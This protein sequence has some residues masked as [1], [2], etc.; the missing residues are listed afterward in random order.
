VDLMP[1]ADEARVPVAIAEAV[2]V[3]EVAGPESID[4]L[5]AG[6]A[7]R[8]LLLVV[9]NCEH[10]IDLVAEI[11][12][13][14]ILRC[15]GVTI[16]AT[17]RET[18]SIDG[19]HAI[20]VRPLGSPEDGTTADELQRHDATRLFVER[21]QAVGTFEPTDADA[22]SIAAICR[23][24][25]G[26]PLAIELAAARTKLLSVTDIE[27]ALDDRFRLL[28]S[29]A[30][31][32]ASRQRTLEASVA[33]SHDLLTEEEQAV[34][35]R[36]GVFPGPFDLDAVAAVAGLGDTM[37]ALDVLTSLVDKSLVTVRPDEHG[38]R[39][40]MLETIRQFALD[41]LTERGEVE[42]TRDAH[43]DHLLAFGESLDVQAYISDAEAMVQTAALFDDL[44]NAVAWAIERG[45]AGD[46]VDLHFPHYVYY[47]VTGRWAD[48]RATVEAVL[49]D[50]GLTLAQQVKAHQMAIGL[51]ASAS[52]PVRG[53]ELA[54]EA[55]RLAREHGDEFLLWGTLGSILSAQVW[56]NT[57][58]SW[59]AEAWEMAGSGKWG[60]GPLML[61]GCFWGAALVYAGRDL[62]AIPVLEAS[63]EAAREMAIPFF[64]V[65]GLTF[66]A[67]AYERLGQVWRTSEF[68][69]RARELAEQHSRRLLGILEPTAGVWE[70]IPFGEYE[71][72]RER[73]R[74]A[75][76]HAG[77]PG[78]STY[79]I[80]LIGLANVAH[81]EGDL[82]TAGPA[83]DEA[84]RLLRK[85][86]NNW[87]LAI[88]L[89]YQAL[90]AA[91]TGDVARARLSL[92]EHDALL[93]S[94]GWMYPRFIGAVARAYIA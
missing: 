21:A 42:A 47:L 27:A 11:L 87:Y 63:I 93:P 51:A 12:D 37:A 57:D 64:E 18:I 62:D 46:A 36:L 90:V 49:E 20:R 6:L 3:R 32:S 76:E 79:N 66:L 92:A 85:G 7:D 16:L 13:L 94:Y 39:Y 86:S 78:S 89:G 38:R 35:A 24:L 17:S 71:I 80:L 4:Q 52:D 69:S 54:P 59:G 34:F 67:G 2:R 68:T 43:L 29:G 74:T 73:I 23:R 70:H 19:E 41:R 33:W 56:V 60:P 28:T 1:V 77:A 44:R 65:Y 83:A 91:E 82:E 40:R 50:P 31:R 26:I 22:P 25:D 75:Q 81:V 5:A 53:V 30:R 9:D 10:V 61:C 8:R 45:R 14:L 55:A 88:G 48:A 58:L 15:P 84:V 72:A